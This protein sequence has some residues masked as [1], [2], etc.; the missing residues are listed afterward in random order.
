MTGDILGNILKL[1]LL[2]QGLACR[3]GQFLACTEHGSRHNHHLATMLVVKAVGALAGKNMCSHVGY[4]LP[5][6]SA[7]RSRL[8]S[9]RNSPPAPPGQTCASPQSA[10]EAR[11]QSLPA[12]NK[13]A[14]SQHRTPRCQPSSASHP[15]PIRATV[16]TESH[17]ANAPARCPYP[18]C[19]PAPPPQ[20]Q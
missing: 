19:S 1:H 4:V 13:A 12:Q 18:P 8:L 3:C 10:A 11:P 2:A 5:S 9:Q 16:L 15:N 7:K 6:S 14:D 20:Y 17:K